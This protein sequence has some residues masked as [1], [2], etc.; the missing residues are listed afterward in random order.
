MISG[1]R[2]QPLLCAFFGRGETIMEL[3]RKNIRILAGLIAFGVLLYVGLQHVRLG[4]V[5]GLFKPFLLGGGIAFVLNVPMRAIERTLLSLSAGQKK[6]RK[7]SKTLYRVVSMLLT[8]A[9][10]IGV[11]MVVCLMI[12]PA[13][14]RSAQTLGDYLSDFYELIAPYIKQLSELYP[15][16]GKLSVSWEEIDWKETGTQVATFVW[17]FLWNGGLIN[18]TVGA[19]ASLVSGVVN[20]FLALVFSIYLLLMKETLARQLKRLGYAYLPEGAMDSVVG[21]GCMVNETFSHFIS[22]QCVEALILGLMFFLVM[23]VGRFPYALMISALIAVTALIPLFGAFIGCIV[24]AFLILIVSPVKAVW[25][26]GIFLILQQIE[27]NL[28]YPRVVGGS[29]GLPAIWVLMAVTLGASTMG[30]AGMFIAIPTFS[31]V[32]Q[33]LRRDSL[34]RVK[35]KRIRPSK[36]R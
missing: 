2:V 7:A 33:L 23:S 1:P 18:G 31:V 13:I 20:F 21:V 17:D 8:F 16:L 10:F 9:L 3:N 32:Y 36:Y 6:R 14:V 5:L 30:V 26:V 15:D 29:V 11:V 22:G 19:A 12:I 4:D 24:G 27:G 25:F 34:K 28:I 35:E